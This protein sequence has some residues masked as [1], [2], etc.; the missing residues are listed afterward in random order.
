MW[1]MRYFFATQGTNFT[2][3]NLTGFFFGLSDCHP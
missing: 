1:K 2:K 3:G